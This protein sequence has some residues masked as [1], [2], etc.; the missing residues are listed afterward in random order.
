M[1]LPAD[2]FQQQTGGTDEAGIKK[3]DFRISWTRNAFGLLLP[4]R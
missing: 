4:C 3:T 1:N 2:V